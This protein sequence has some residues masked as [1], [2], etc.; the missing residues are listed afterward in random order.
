MRRRVFLQLG[1][2]L[3]KERYAYA[4]R[5]SSAKFRYS[6]NWLSPDLPFSSPNDLSISHSQRVS[7]KVS[8]S[9]AA[10]LNSH[11]N[12]PE[13]T[14]LAGPKSD[15]EPAGIRLQQSGITV[16]ACVIYQR[17]GDQTA[18]SINLPIITLHSPYGGRRVS[19]G[20]LIR[21]FLDFFSYSLRKTKREATKMANILEDGGGVKDIWDMAI[22]Q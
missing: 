1:A 5:K 13:G 20:C 8:R 18:Q 3:P 16:R 19:R 22:I 15:P 4:A 10:S 9:L 11:E 14:R 21:S 12:V 6:Y 2:H 17:T 7:R